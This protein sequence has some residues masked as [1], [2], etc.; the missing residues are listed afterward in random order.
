MEM[1]TVGD[2]ADLEFD[3]IR[4]EK[5]KSSSV[6]SPFKP[7]VKLIPVSTYSVFVVLFIA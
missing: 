2:G 5:V 7:E 6:S 1:K 4:H 3:L